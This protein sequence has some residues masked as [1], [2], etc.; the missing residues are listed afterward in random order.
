MAFDLDKAFQ[1]DIA[2][3]N[4]K[5]AHSLVFKLH[6]EPKFPFI[7]WLLENPN[8]IVALPGKISLLH[9]DYIHILLGRGISSQD[10]AFVIGFTMG[11]DLKTNQLHLFI[12]QVFAKFIYPVP[13]KFSSLDLISFKLGFFYG[14]KIKIKQINEINFELYQSENV[15]FLRDFF[16]INT[17]E[18]KLLQEY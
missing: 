10:E 2:Q 11:N 15:G 16:G 18:S 3:M 12:Y 17:D 8:S 13:Y 5:K 7:I 14:R 1:L 9:H 4:L 6:G